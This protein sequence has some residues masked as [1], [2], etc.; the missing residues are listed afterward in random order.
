[1]ED[2]S[3]TTCAAGSIAEAEELHSLPDAA[4]PTSALP[5]DVGPARTSRSLSAASLSRSR[6]LN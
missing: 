1:M 6:R 5:D 2:T 3:S 4:G